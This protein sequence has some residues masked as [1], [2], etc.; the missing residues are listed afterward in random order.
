M[1]CRWSSPRCLLA[2]LGRDGGL[3]A[4]LAPPEAT[5]AGLADGRDGITRPGG[6]RVE[7]AVRPAQ[8]EPAEHPGHHELAE[9]EDVAHRQ[10]VGDELAPHE[11]GGVAR[12]DDEAEIPGEEEDRRRDDEGLLSPDQ[13]TELRRS[14]DRLPVDVRVVF[15]HGNTPPQVALRGRVPEAPSP[16]A[17]SHLAAGGWARVAAQHALVCDG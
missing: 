3:F 15:G 16:Y 4:E 17:Q 9:R 10:P 1:R 6:E 14:L 2:R 8:V 12:K 13:L 11:V 7:N 5:L